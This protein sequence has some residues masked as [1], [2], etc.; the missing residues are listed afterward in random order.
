MDAQAFEWELLVYNAHDEPV[1]KRFTKGITRFLA[2]L[3][4][5][6]LAIDDSHGLAVYPGRLRTAISLIWTAL[7]RR[8]TSGTALFSAASTKAASVAQGR[9]LFH[10]QVLAVDM[11]ACSPDR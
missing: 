3:Y 11:H 5:V 1:K 7:L 4:F 8:S 9:R 6:S 10:E 2:S